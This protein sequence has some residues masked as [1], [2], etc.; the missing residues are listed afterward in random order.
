MGCSTSLCKQLTVQ[1]VLKDISD[2]DDQAGHEIVVQDYVP[3]GTIDRIALSQRLTE[4]EN[5]EIVAFKEL[6]RDGAIEAE[7]P[8]D[9]T[10]LRSIRF[11]AC[12]HSIQGQA[13]AALKVFNSFQSWH[14]KNAIQASSISWPPEKMEVL[15]R[16]YPQYFRY[17]MAVPASRY[18][19]F[20]YYD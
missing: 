16:F 1:P 6:L 4:A 15:R 2:N 8:D 11:A 17:I 7:V 19:T 5:N 13:P 20:Q 12:G 3:F 10:I 14:H 18:I 9:V